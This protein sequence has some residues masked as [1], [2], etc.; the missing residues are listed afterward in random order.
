M[1]LDKSKDLIDLV[2]VSGWKNN[3]YLFLAKY[4]KSKGIN[5]ILTMDNHWKNELKQ[6]FFTLFSR[7]FS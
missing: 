5:V 4:Y 6:Y 1:I 3:K 7:F 2:Y